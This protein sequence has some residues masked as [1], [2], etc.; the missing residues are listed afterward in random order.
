MNTYTNGKSAVAQP[1]NARSWTQISDTVIVNKGDEA[2]QAT[3]DA[4]ANVRYEP[5]ISVRV[6]TDAAGQTTVRRTRPYRLEQPTLV[7]GI[8]GTGHRII[9]MLKSYFLAT[10]GY[11]PMNLALLCFDSASDPVSAINERTGEVVTLEVGSEFFPFDP[12]PVQ[13]IKNN[14]VHHGEMASTMSAE[15]IRR[16]NRAVITHGAAQDR[17]QGLMALLW[18]GK[19][20]ERIVGN[21]LHRLTEREKDVHGEL[22][23]MNTIQVYVAGSL[24]GGQGAGAMQALCTMIG[25]HMAN[26]STL[27][28][29]GRIVG[30]AVLPGAFHGIENQR[31]QANTLASVEE[32]NAFTRG[33]VENRIHYPGGNPI[34]TFEPPADYLYVFDGVDENGRAW[35]NVE[36]VCDA[37]ARLVWLLSNSAVGMREINAMINE[38]MA[39]MGVSD[40][41]YG[42]Y[43]ATAGTATITY[44][45]AEVAERCAIRQ[46]QS[47]LTFILNGVYD[48]AAL[49]GVRPPD[50]VSLTALRERLATTDEGLPHQVRLS[51]P[52]ALE[53]L[54][55]EE[56]PAKTRMLVDNHMR[57]RVED[58]AFS[59]ILRKKAVALQEGGGLLLQTLNGYLD[60]GRLR[61]ARGFLA[62]V[63]EMLERGL[64]ELAK[65][66][67]RFAQLEEQNQGALVSAG[68]ALEK[69]VGNFLTFNRRAQVRTALGIYINEANALAAQRV[70]RK[71]AECAAEI[72]RSLLTGA[73]QQQRLLDAAIA[74][75]HQGR[76]WLAGHEL[77]LSRRAGGRAE[78]SLADDEL[79]DELYR[80]HASQ[81]AVDAPAALKELGALSNWQHLRPQEIAQIVVKSVTPSFEPVRRLTVED[82]LSLRWNE[83]SAQNWISRLES[84]AAA[85]WNPDRSLL[86]GGG[87]ELASFLTIGVPDES[88]SIFANSGRTLVSTHDPERI[89]ALRTVYGGSFD[90]LKPFA[91]WKRAYEALAPRVPL[92]IYPGFRRT[93]DLSVQTFALSMVYGLIAKKGNWYY[94]TP[95]DP[96]AAP[97]QLALGLEN[98]VRAFQ[99][100]REMQEEARGRITAQ[101]DKEGSA[102]TAAR[103]K[104]WVGSGN[105]TDETMQRLR[106]S[107][108]EHLE[109]NVAQQ[110]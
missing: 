23:T 64:A 3:F 29:R 93:E 49:P 33:K 40:G 100:Q 95:A 83:R 105:H 53:Q 48:A 102:Q 36:D 5:Q 8:G 4:A 72:L 85:G 73:Q 70:E 30:I 68:A 104:G 37:A 7:V 50:G 43:L 27:G 58:E 14:L 16:I 65:E 94:F 24:A 101:M 59:A 28:E 10:R 77:E 57:R 2:V 98:A 34:R 9:T 51:P 13:G 38:T 6:E 62:V 89:I 17:S 91:Q 103:I 66:Q 26:A 20:V 107:A 61:E 18:N 67:E 79:V 41:D 78:I 76:E 45:S 56:V 25:H 92:H 87:V 46:A 22:A 84:L 52:A 82:V 31:M 12:V 69:S 47:V 63:T 32:W 15:A 88:R 109:R 106:R 81:P 90:A 44:R 39:L 55:V 110:G 74:R 80:K 60:N 1:G 42:T 99:E 35:A 97:V 108:L 54:P 96:L 19:E 21:A 11:Q 71:V 86:R 75:M